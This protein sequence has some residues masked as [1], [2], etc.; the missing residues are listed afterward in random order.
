VTFVIDKEEIQDQATPPPPEP[1]DPFA[2]LPEPT[3]DLVEK[4]GKPEDYE[5]R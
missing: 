5:T 3:W 2:N 1:E 4:G